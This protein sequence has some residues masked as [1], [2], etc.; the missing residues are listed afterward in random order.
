MTKR[1]RVTLTLTEEKQIEFNAMAK[2]IGFT[3]SNFLAYLLEK[4]KERERAEVQV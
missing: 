4:E 3:K 2:K 1:N